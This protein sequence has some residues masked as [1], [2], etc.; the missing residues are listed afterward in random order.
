MGM[1]KLR[2]PCQLGEGRCGRRASPYVGDGGWKVEEVV[3][4]FGLGKG[5]DGS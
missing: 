5:V 2:G 3:G 1:L 4:C